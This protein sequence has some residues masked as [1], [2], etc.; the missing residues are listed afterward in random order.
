MSVYVIGN[1][2]LHVPFNRTARFSVLIELSQLSNL[3]LSVISCKYVK[4]IVTLS[5]AEQN[6]FTD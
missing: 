1:V 5:A 6:A 2:S 3:R 4:R